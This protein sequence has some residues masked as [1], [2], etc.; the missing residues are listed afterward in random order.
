[1][2]TEEHSCCTPHMR[3]GSPLH[4][5]PA[6][7]QAQ[8]L[9]AEEPRDEVLARMVPLTGGTFRMGSD[10]P[11]GFAD[12]G[13]GPVRAVT[14]DPFHIDK[15]PVTNA[16]F[17]KFV[18]AT[19]YKTEAERFGWSF[20]FWSH[21]SRKRFASLVEDTVFDAH[22]HMTATLTNPQDPPHGS[23]RVMKGG[24]FLRHRSY[25]NRYRVGARTS[26]TPDSTSAHVGFRCAL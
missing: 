23:G 20:V 14:L 11:E 9:T 22:F 8:A 10:H 25:C 15:H 18:A 4:T 6:I 3:Q 5:P 17:S 13:E 21:I 2:P 19:G 24:S 26:N 12:D 1:M 16:L 7:A